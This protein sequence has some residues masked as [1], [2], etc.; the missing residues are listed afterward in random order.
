ML[1]SSS[2]KPSIQTVWYHALPNWSS[3]LLSLALVLAPYVDASA[4]NSEKDKNNNVSFLS[5]NSTG[6]GDTVTLPS[7][8]VLKPKS[9]PKPASLLADT[10]NTAPAVQLKDRGIL[11]QGIPEEGQISGKDGQTK[12][13]EELI[14][15]KQY[16]EMAKLGDEMGDKELLKYL[17][18][19]VTT[20][21]HFK[22][23]FGYLEQR[24][25]VPSFLAHGK[26][27][28]IGKVIVETS[29]LKTRNGGGCD[30]IYDGIVLSLKEDSH[31]RAASLFE[32]ARGRPGWKHKFDR[33]VD[34]FFVRW[35]PEK[36]SMPL[37]R[38]LS[39]YGEELS[40]KHP[41][42]FKTIC[43]ELVW[44]LSYQL[45]NPVLQKLLIALVGQPSLLT[46]VA[47]ARGF[48][49]YSY[50]DISRINFIMYGYKEALEEGLKKAYPRGS[51]KLWGVMVSTHPTQFSGEYPDTDEA[52]SI[53][54]K[55]FKPTKHDLEEAWAKEHAPMLLKHLETLVAELP[56]Y[57]DLL[58]IIAGYAITW[59]VV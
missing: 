56:L 51:I 12:R 42:I 55:N 33:F 43:E 58:S 25:M 6:R 39:L 40:K 10:T 17:C 46:P 29:L 45:D 31:E 50:Q 16:E 57:R 48:L 26:M 36:D 2:T 23:L 21:D 52:R 49:E 19:V 27:V 11:M 20:L 44:E 7:S 47:F 5:D 4:K 3:L 32:A 13:F 18:Q 38:F 9:K 14:S 8:P 41:V 37:K 59:V 53:A 24:N 34:G 22:G 15:K 30:S 35:F 1:P 54:L 28:L